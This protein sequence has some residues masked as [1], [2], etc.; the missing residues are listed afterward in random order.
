MLGCGRRRREPRPPRQHRG[1]EALPGTPWSSRP[2][3]QPL[4]PDGDGRCGW[5]M[6]RKE[7]REDRAAGLRRGGRCGAESH[8]RGCRWLPSGCGA[9]PKNRGPGEHPQPRPPGVGRAGGGRGLQ[10]PKGPAG[11]WAGPVPRAWGGCRAPA[12]RSPWLFWDVPVL[13]TCSELHTPSP[14]RAGA[15]GCCCTI[16]TPLA[17]ALS[18]SPGGRRGRGRKG[19]HGAAPSQAPPQGPPHSLQPPQA[20]RPWPS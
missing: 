20:T 11:S 4:P 17:L 16:F 10:A 2:R 14:R 15:G 6:E 9:G 5:V 1:L 8:G 3:R 7:R 13:G 18:C 12:P 19:G